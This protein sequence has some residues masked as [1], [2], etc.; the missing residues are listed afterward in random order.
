MAKKSFKDWVIATRPWSFPA[1]SMPVV[2]TMAYIFYMSKSVGTEVIIGMKDFVSEGINWTNGWIA[3]AMMI[4]FQAA[5]NLVSDY[6]DHVKGVDRPGSLN[7]VRHIQSGKFTPKEVLNFGLILTGV[8]ALLGL[9]LLSRSSFSLFWFG[10]LGISLLL[11]YPKLKANALGDVDILLCYALIPSLGTSYVLT[12]TYH[13]EVMLLSLTYGLLIVAILHANNTRDILNDRGAN[14]TTL[15][16]LIGGK[17]SKYIYLAEVMI[18]YILIVIFVAVG[19]LPWIVLF[20]FVTLPIAI[21]NISVMMK[22]RPENEED[23]ATLDKSTAGMELL[24]S[25]LLSALLV[26]AGVMLKN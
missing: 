20:V 26:I 5:G 9:L 1:S 15:C 12:G 24:F 22:A 23:I 6:S 11:F 14:L 8:A 4:V 13:F 19:W 10:L 2:V 21:K 18:P 3:L 17:I 25:L 7:G 16:G